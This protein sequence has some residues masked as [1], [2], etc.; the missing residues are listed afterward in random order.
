MDCS[1]HARS[2][3][4]SA[5]QATSPLFTQ[6]HPLVFPQILRV[7]YAIA[8]GTGAL[9]FKPTLVIPAQYVLPLTVQSYSPLKLLAN[10]PALENIPAL[11]C[12]CLH[13]LKMNTLPL[14]LPPSSSF[15]LWTL[16]FT[17]L[18]DPLYFHSMS[19]T[20]TIAHASGMLTAPNRV[21]TSPLTVSRP[22]TSV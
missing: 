13:L 12:S 11:Y 17:Q 14:T 5:F 19:A 7:M 20:Q 4:C 8:T 9:F 16:V 6:F 21:H 2:W 18:W 3:F 1:L 10:S 15:M 22:F